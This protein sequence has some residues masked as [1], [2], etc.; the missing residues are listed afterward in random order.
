MPKFM[1]TEDFIIQLF[2]MID[3]EMKNVPKH[4]Q[5]KLYPSEI[6]TIGILSATKRCLLKRSFPL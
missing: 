3:D 6:V 5:S 2:C 4:S 1:P